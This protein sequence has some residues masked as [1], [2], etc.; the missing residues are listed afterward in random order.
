MSDKASEKALSD[1]DEETPKK[2]KRRSYKKKPVS[3]E[4]Y[5]TES[6]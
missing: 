6:N 2:K 4:D 5:D 1:N 3:A